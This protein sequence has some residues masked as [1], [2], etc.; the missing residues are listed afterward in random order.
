MHRDVANALERG[1]MAELRAASARIGKSN[2][3][4]MLRPAIPAAPSA[5]PRPPARRCRRAG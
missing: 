1:G 3:H 2:Q 5:R 4:F